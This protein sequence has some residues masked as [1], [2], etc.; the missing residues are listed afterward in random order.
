MSPG[1]KAENCLS[2]CMAAALHGIH[3]CLANSR[4]QKCHE[5]LPHKVRE[6][7]CGVRIS[8]PSQLSRHG[9]RR[10]RAGRDSQ[11]R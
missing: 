3:R 7:P 6:V 1:S 10:P 9:R 4:P 5:T 11:C 2:E 8:Q